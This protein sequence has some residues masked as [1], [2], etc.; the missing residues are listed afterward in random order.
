MEIKNAE[1]GT[2]EVPEVG[3]AL[4]SVEV[5]R[6]GILRVYIISDADDVDGQTDAHRLLARVMAQLMLL[7]DALKSEGGLVDSGTFGTP[8]VGGHKQ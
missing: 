7:D 1:S 4:I 2:L 8:T 5:G 3:N 6:Q